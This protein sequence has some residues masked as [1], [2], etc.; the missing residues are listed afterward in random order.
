MMKEKF[1][2]KK[3]SI[4]IFTPNNNYN[5]IINDE[6]EK[7]DKEKITINFLLPN[8]NYNFMINNER[9][10]TIKKNSQLIFYCLIIIII[11]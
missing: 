8:N 6:R 7:N 5:Y 1:T 3:K 2:I 4:E 9:E 11:I 10:K